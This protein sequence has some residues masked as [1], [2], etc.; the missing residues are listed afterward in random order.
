MTSRLPNSRTNL[1]FT[2]VLTMIASACH[3]KA[4]SVAVSPPL[5]VAIVY[6]GATIW[7]G[8]RRDRRRHRAGLL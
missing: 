8:T 3:G 2:I 7:I 5:A 4:H 6:D 1:F